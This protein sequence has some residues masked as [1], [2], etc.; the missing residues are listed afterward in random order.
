[1]FPP[2]SQYRENPSDFHI[3][4]RFNSAQVHM[5]I[6]SLYINQHREYLRILSFSLVTILFFFLLTSRVGRYEWMDKQGFERVFLLHTSLSP[7]YSIFLSLV[8]LLFES[9]LFSLP[10]G[11][12]RLDYT[13]ICQYFQTP[14]Q[15]ESELGR[16]E[17]K[18]AV[19]TFPIHC[20]NSLE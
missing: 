20:T 11:E 6:S 14:S 1:M 13:G 17:I 9:Y 3:D 2:I 5:E 10:N 4:Q 8:I 12:R 15:D 16:K 7:S 19:F 18:S